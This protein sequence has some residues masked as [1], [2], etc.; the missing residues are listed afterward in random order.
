MKEILQPTEVIFLQNTKLPL[1]HER[2]PWFAH[3]GSTIKLIGSSKPGQQNIEFVVTGSKEFILSYPYPETNRERAIKLIEGLFEKLKEGNALAQPNITAST[4]KT[5]AYLGQL[6]ILKDSI[7]T[8]FE[9]SSPLL[10]D[11]VTFLSNSTIQA[12]TLY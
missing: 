12:L 8:E 5:L 9:D 2:E 10:A 1:G 4:R 7:V 11:F 6:S 3:K